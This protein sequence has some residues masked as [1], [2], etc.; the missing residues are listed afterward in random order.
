MKRLWLLCGLVRQ[1]QE[2]VGLPVWIAAAAAT[3]AVAADPTVINAAISN[4]ASAHAK[5]P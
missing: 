4:V 1:L 2:K 5:S 3:P